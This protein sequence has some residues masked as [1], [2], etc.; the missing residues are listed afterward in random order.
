MG[1]K[2]SNALETNCLVSTHLHEGFGFLSHTITLETCTTNDHVGEVERSIRTIKE[3]VRATAHGMPYCRLPRQLIHGLVEYA[4][5]TLNDF[6]YRHGVS[7]SLSPNTIVTGR[8][9]PDYN[10]LRLEFGSYV[11][12]TDWT[13]NTP[14]ARTFGAIA[15]YP[16]GN[17]DGS[18]RFMSLATG[19]IVSKAPRYWTELP[20]PDHAIA[21]VEF[22]A[23]DQGQPT[24]QD[25]NFLPEFSPDQVIDEDEY[26]KD[27]EL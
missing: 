5:R 20:I 21:R 12:L 10:D 6:P 14:R 19:E 25:S 27:Y 16:S 23:K 22:L 7:Q 13:T 1:I 2:S 4:T 18:Y 15:M 11:M 24:L 26:D 8:P 17:R 9:P 3:V